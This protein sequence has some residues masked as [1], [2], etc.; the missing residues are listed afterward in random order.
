MTGIDWGKGIGPSS[1]LVSIGR[2]IDL[3]T[4]VILCFNLINC[5]VRR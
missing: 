1:S 3:S 4:S 2:S 5:C